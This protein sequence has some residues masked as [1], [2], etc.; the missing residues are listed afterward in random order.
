MSSFI[1]KDEYN[2]Y[3]TKYDNATKRFLQEAIDSNICEFLR[4]DGTYIV[5]KK[6][7]LQE[8]SEKAIGLY[9]S[10]KDIEIWTYVAIE[11]NYGI[12]DWLSLGNY[13]VDDDFNTVV[14]KALK[15]A[16]TCNYCKEEVGYKDIQQVS[17][18]GKSCSKCISKARAIDETPGWYN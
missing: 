4:D 9:I 11:D 18:A 16:R 14:Q 7:E 15:S 5:V 10:I 6:P 8:L 17:F 1:P 2:D 13:S 12:R 3:L